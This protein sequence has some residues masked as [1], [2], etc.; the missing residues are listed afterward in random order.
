ML[1]DLDFSAIVVSGTAQAVGEL[2]W[3]D[4]PA[5]FSFDKLNGKIQL[6]I[7]KGNIIEVDAGAGRLLGLFSLSALPRRLFGDFK[8]T[9]KSG[10][11]FDTARGVVEIENGDAYMDDF[12]ITSVVADIMVSGRTGLAERDYENTIV[13]IPETGDSVAGVTALLV[14]LPAGVGVW[15]LSKITGEKFNQASSSVYEITGSW[16]KPV[17]EEIKQ[18]EQIEEEDTDEE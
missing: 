1:T 13:V 6:N 9:F 12:K 8:D 5:K 18:I 3:Q 7:E 11:T 10:F 2:S 15:L 4:A 14:S 16:D 17:I